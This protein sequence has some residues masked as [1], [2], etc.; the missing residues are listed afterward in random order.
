MRFFLNLFYWVDYCRQWTPSQRRDFL[1]WK[2]R[3]LKNSLARLLGFSSSAVPAMEVENLIDLAALPEQQRDLWQAH[4]RALMKFSPSPIPGRVHLF[5]SPG[6]PL[7]CSFEPDYGW[8]DLARGGVNV[9][10]VRGSARKNSRGAVG[11]RNCRGHQERSSRTLAKRIWRFGS[12]SSKDA[13]MQIDLPVAHAAPVPRESTIGVETRCLPVALTAR[14]DG[15]EV[16][17][18]ALA[19]LNL[20]LGRYSAQDDILVGIQIGGGQEPENTVVLR[21]NIAGNP[22][23]REL[24]AR[25]RA[26][27]SSARQ[28]DSVPFKDV[29][30]ELCPGAAGGS[31]PSLQIFFAHGT[32]PHPEKFDLRFCW[33]DNE[34]GAALRLEYREDLFDRAAMRRML[35]HMEVA[36]QRLLES[37]E[38]PA[39]SLSILTP[40][41]ADLLSAW[42]RTEARFSGGQNFI[43]VV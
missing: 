11:R 27:I 42:N 28:H 39:S 8:G 4:I 5:R 35:G 24:L 2:W 16:S 6:H 12:R 43:S 22:T 15:K 32:M 40:A 9:A 36:L 18:V 10:V 37:P 33:I 38:K 20:V 29:L 30:A 21:T 7:W 23:G 31:Q 3:R 1:R 41:E 26:A 19:A 34:A 14:V 13:P 25:V 17:N